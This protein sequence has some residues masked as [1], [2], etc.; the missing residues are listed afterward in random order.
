M[1]KRKRSRAGILVL[2]QLD[3]PGKTGPVSQSPPVW[4]INIA[5]ARGNFPRQGLLCRAGPWTP[6]TQGDSVKV[7][8]PKGVEVLQKIVG[9]GQENT[10]LQMF[11]PS[12][13]IDEGFAEV[14]YSVKRVGQAEEPSEDIQVLVK[15]TRPAGHDDNAEPGHSKLI[16]S[17]PPD[18][19]NGGID[20]DNVAAGVPITIERYPFIAPG[21]VIQL[22]WGGIFVLSSPLRQAQVDGTAPIIVH[23]SEA[24]IREAEDS[25]DI[26][27]SVVFEVYDEVENRSEDWSMPQRVVVAIDKTRLEAPI[28]K[29]A[30][31]NVL[32]VDKLNNA[33]GHAQ[34][35]VTASGS[36]KLGDIP[37]IRIKGTPVEGAP[38]DVEFSGKALISVPITAE[39]PI[40][41]AV[42]QQLVK[43][44]IA[45]SYRLKKADGSADLR[46]KTQFLSAIGT[47]QRLVA[48]KALDAV[49]GALDPALKQV[50]IE[51]PFDA[52]FAAGQAIKLFWLGTRPELI[53]YLPDLPLR[54]ITNGDISAGLPLLINVD[55]AQLTPIIGGT[56]EL[57]YHLLIEDGVL[58]A[59]NYV[60]AMHAVRESDH[61]DILRVGEPRLELPEPVVA[62]V[63]DGALPA[64]TNGTTLTVN[65]LSTAKGD[66][67]IYEWH[68]SKISDSDSVTLSSLTAGQPVQFNIK[69]EFI[70][71]NEGETV[72]ASYDIKRA[73]GGTSYSNPLAFRIGAA[74]ENPL[75]VA[76]LPQATGSGANVTLAPLDA[77]T[78]VKVLVNYSGMNA[79]QFIQLT[80]IGTPGAGSPPIAGKPGL[81]SGS[82]EFLIPPGALAANIG[83]AAKT[84][85]LQ[86]EVTQGSLKIPSL[87]LTVTVTPLP[88]SELDKLSIL[89]AVGDELDISKVTAGATVSAGVWA[90]IQVGQPVW[91]VLMGTNTQG[92]E[93]NL[94]VWK[95]P[96]AGVNAGW[97]SA[98]K[99]DQGVYYDYFKA[100]ADGSDLKLHFK[101]A[102]TSSQVEADAIVA[103]VKTYRIKAVADVKP[104]ITS[105]KDS[106]GAE[107]LHGGTTVDTRVILTGTASKG[108]T[109]DVLDG[110]VS[111][112]KPPVDPTTGVWTLDVSNLSIAAHSFT[113]K[114]E[115]GAGP[116]SAAR[117]LTVLALVTPVINSVKDS[118]GIAI[119]QNGLTVDPNVKVS[120]TAARNQ[121]ILIYNNG[122][123]TAFTAI[124]DDLGNWNRDLTGLAQGDCN[125][126]AVAQYGSKPESPP[127]KITITLMVTPTINS[128]KDSQGVEIPHGG[129]TTDTSVTIIGTASKGQKVDVK[130]GAVSKGMPIVD[131]TNGIWTQEV[132]SLSISEH[133][134]TAKA[135]YGEQSISTQWNFKNLPPEEFENFESAAPGIIQT[136]DLHAMYIRKTGSG[137]GVLIQVITYAPHITGKALRL[138]WDQGVDITLKNSATKIRFG[139]KSLNITWFSIKIFDDNNTNKSFSIIPYPPNYAD[140]AEFF[141]D[142]RRRIKRITIF[143]QF[144]VIKD[145]GFIDNF[146]IFY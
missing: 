121:T 6:M 62:G 49:N 37:I 126:T 10:T 50:R 76:H 9:P 123:S 61:A 27:L 124:A 33:D 112:G 108:Q 98:G 110:T 111:K 90:F 71:G 3:I 131:P 72:S 20:K 22:S 145:A 42:L 28:L 13:L 96:G 84:F 85:T 140:W 32:D 81:A 105:I 77:K 117:T 137:N 128:I 59:M 74:L 4:G 14:S 92:A 99:F 54:P 79:S 12:A 64:D 56:L 63:V 25:D 5:A 122:V 120:G 142:D 16:F 58:G 67:V 91:L 103:P 86:Y 21:D 52:S 45:L 114:A 35:W 136:L 134:F 83:N 60:N 138:P 46:S 119:P 89:Q 139:F 73:A 75:P 143:A 7:Y 104:V 107:I 38:I 78:G 43:S 95:V 44:Q 97:I 55:G 15:L 36:F 23:V 146:T 102:L 115:Y 2:E 135:L 57:Y 11:I 132:S 19:L 101:A 133:S 48:P 8:W 93:H 144:H 88:A 18:I 53:P 94:V 106:K 17:I 66:E 141:F 29:E 118:K 125:L 41:F 68:G 47:V 26:G 34:V 1:S 70:K 24:V 51:I 87:S 39:I 80:M 69:A 130:D 116:V 31:N 129:T 65:Y 82:V 109:V 30:L 100:L 40:P 127:W 113:A